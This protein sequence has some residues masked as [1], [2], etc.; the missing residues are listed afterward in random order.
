M[1]VEHLVADARKQVNDEALKAGERVLSRHRS[2][3]GV[4]LVIMTEGNRSGTMI[5]LPGDA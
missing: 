1:G 5:L 3:E 4:E 2:S